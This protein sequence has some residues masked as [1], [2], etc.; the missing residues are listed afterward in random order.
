MLFAKKTL[1]LPTLD[2]ALGDLVRRVRWPSG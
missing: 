2:T 1:D